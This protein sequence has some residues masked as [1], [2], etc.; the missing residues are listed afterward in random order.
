MDQGEDSPPINLSD[1]E[2]LKNKLLT[3]KELLEEKFIH[4]FMNEFENEEEN[5]P[6]TSADLGQQQSFEKAQLKLSKCS[7]FLA[8]R[9]K[10]VVKD[11]IAQKQNDQ[12]V[13]KYGII[14]AKPTNVSDM[15]Q[16]YQKCF[17]A[18]LNAVDDVSFRARDTQLL[19]N[20]EIRDK[21]TL[22]FFSMN[23]TQRQVAD[24]MPQ[25]IVAGETSTGKEIYFYHLIINSVDKFVCESIRRGARFGDYIMLY[26]PL[27]TKGRT[28]KSVS[29][30]KKPTT[31][32][33]V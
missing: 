21:F 15:A 18:F 26:K 32:D 7:L 5:L 28:K 4:Q 30:A 22:V 10:P 1:L 13:S 16:N 31:N 3:K 6:G 24:N 12:L 8:Q 20:I 11:I 23:T 2:L 33:Q 9:F 27:L 19:K 14:K 17:N 29:T 25:L